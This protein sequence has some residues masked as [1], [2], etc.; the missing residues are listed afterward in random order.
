LADVNRSFFRDARAKRVRRERLN[1]ELQS[2]QPME[3]QM[4][5]VMYLIL[6]SL[7]LSGTITMA[8]AASDGVRDIATSTQGS[9]DIWALE[10][11]IDV[12]SLPAGDLDPAIY[13]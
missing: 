11:A 9:L 7:V 1:F 4:T 8:S 3:P 5:K 12:K 13:Q 10:R 6:G 2:F